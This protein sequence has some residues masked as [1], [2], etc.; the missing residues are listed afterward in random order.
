MNAHIFIDAENI[1]P[2]IG[3]RAVDKFR[4]D[5]TIE[6]VDIIGK[7]DTIS[8]RYKNAGEPYRV[9]NCF[10]GK[11]SADTWLCVEIAKTIF[12]EPLTETIII[13]SNDKD[14]LPA[15]KLAVD[16]K[17]YVI[18]VSNGTG[19]KNL[20]RYLQAIKINSDYVELID[21]RDGLTLPTDEGDIRKKKSL[22]EL[23]KD[24]EPI[25]PKPVSKLEVICKKLSD[26]LGNFFMRRAEQVKFIFIK[27]GNNFA[28]VP[29]I[30]GMTISQFASL[31]HELQIVGKKISG[32][33]AAQE[34]FLKVV[35]EKIFFYSEKEL[36]SSK[37]G[38]LSKFSG[39]SQ[40]SI[41]YFI[42]NDLNL[43]TIFIKHGGNIFEVPFVNGISVQIFSIVLREMKI[44]GKNASFQKIMAANFLDV[45]ENRIYLQT[46]ETISVKNIS[47]E[48]KFFAEHNAEIKIIFVKHA[49]KIFE[50]P[51]VNGMTR[52]I[53]FAVL[54]RKNITNKKKELP[55]IISDSSLDLIGDKIYLQS[56]EK[57]FESVILKGFTIN[58]DKLSAASM[59]FLAD[60]DEQ[61][62]F[63]SI[64]YAGI[65]HK[66]P[67]V[68]G[69]NFL[70]L[71]KIMRELKVC[72]K[73]AS[74]KKI[75][76]NNQ[77][78]IIGNA[79]Y[80]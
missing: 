31:L 56:E 54:S 21:Y 67:F 38:I 35:G 50:V 2:D 19:H 58:F 26:A 76:V 74:T 32:M 66:V 77:F 15:I 48:E 65:L 45:I 63:V 22:A 17:K 33:Q 11:N 53:F 64:T 80:I 20:R 40:S 75:L 13:L 18:F 57:I 47:S 1:K 37:I 42:S 46:E 8:A 24:V 55:Q 71:S 10:Y 59:K 16:R 36:R 72:G 52:E 73:R 70:V 78:K 27:R 7:F 41:K 44:I 29:F 3:F 69:M 62:K 6:R 39:L 12:E 49:E 34:N 43:R 60:N 79:V 30:E 61:I 28:E 68:N 23:M 51:F 14:F 5:F 9:Q 4:R 25:I